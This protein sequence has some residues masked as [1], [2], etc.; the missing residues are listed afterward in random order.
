MEG[1]EIAGGYAVVE[2]QGRY[3]DQQ[4]G[5]RKA[6]T[7]GLVLA[8]DLTDAKSDRRCDWMNRQGRQQFLDKLLPLRFALCCVGT[9]CTVGQFDESYNRQSDL[10]VPCCVG[11]VGEHP[12]SVLPLPLVS[13]Q[14]T[15]IRISP[16]RAARALR[17]GSR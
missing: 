15:G 11:D 16:M 13:D 5:K 17:D 9:S 1:A 12:P 8:V 2:F 7:F 4:I 14:H 3:S 6:H 10:G